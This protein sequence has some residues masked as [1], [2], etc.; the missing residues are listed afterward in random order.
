MND[1]KRNPAFETLLEFLRDNRGFDF[2]GYKRPSLIRRVRHRMEDL[3][4]VETFEAYQDYLEVH[5]DEFAYLF[6]TILINVTSFFRDPEAWDCLGEEVVPQILEYN[7]SSPI[8]VWSAGCAGGEEPYTLAMVFAEAMGVK[9]ALDRLKIYATD[10]DEQAL[11]QARQ[12]SYRPEATEPIPDDLR[13]KYFELSGGQ[14]VFRGDL[15][16]CVV[17]GRHDLIQDAPISRLDLLVCRNT[18]IYLNAQTQRRVLAR[19]H[20]ALNDPGFLFLGRAE[21]LL[22][23][24]HL[25]RP[26]SEEHRIFEKVPAA[27]RQDRMIALTQAGNGAAAVELGSYVRLREAAFGVAPLSQV[28]IDAEEHLALAND[29]ARAMF[30][31]RAADLGRPFQDLE[32]SYRPA[33]LRGPIRRAQGEGHPIKLEGIERSVGE[34]ETQYLDIIV[35]P[36]R[37]NGDRSLGCSI[38]FRDVTDYHTLEEELRNSQ[39]E[40]E[41]AYEELQSSNEELE[42][43]NE[44]LQSTV[45]ELQTTN[46]EL[47]SSNEEMETMNEELRTANQELQ[48]KNQQ[49]RQHRQRLNQTNTFLQSI[50]SSVEAGVV[51]INRDFEILLWNEEAEDLWGLRADEVEGRSLLGLDIGLPVEKLAEPVRDFIAAGEEGEEQVIELDAVNRRGQSIVV[52]ITNTLRRGPDEEIEGVVL[53]M[54]RMD[55]EQ[56]Q[57]EAS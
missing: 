37:A 31:L 30:D 16:R 45:E 4:E 8:R 21:M 1:E 44:E 32:I 47:Q 12:G 49:L 5:P 34:G 57:K 36:L 46:E 14:Y 42:T 54:R 35:I 27:G 9:E 48:Q 13:D 41:T 20:F 40:L 19:F 11:S 24:S 7:P 39:E 2:T 55:T 22:T 43:T 53:M 38:V 15:R 56:A 18:L 3:D 17:F 6:N 23:H 52:H 28:V 10:V 29:A 33:E 50:L 25:F 26:A 51:V